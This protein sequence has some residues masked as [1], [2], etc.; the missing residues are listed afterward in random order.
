MT[1]KTTVPSAA[2]AAAVQY[3][4]V[5][6]SVWTISYRFSDQ[7]EPSKDSDKAADKQPT[8]RRRFFRGKL[9][10][11]F[12]NDGYTDIV[13]QEALGAA[14]E[15]AVIVKAWGWDSEQSS[16]DDDDD[17]REQEYLLFSIDANLQTLDEGDGEPT[18]RTQRFYFQ[19]RQEKDTRSKTVSLVDGTVTIKQDVLRQSSRWAL[20]SPTGIL[21][22][23]RY[24]GDFIAKPYSSNAPNNS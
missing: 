1:P 12:R 18:T 21:A 6:D 24:V 13:A 10:V 3:T 16:D 2:V 14:S 22:Q 5:A 15:Q 23:F 7:P 8:E 17:G 11:K 4:E 19:A 9:V 20:F